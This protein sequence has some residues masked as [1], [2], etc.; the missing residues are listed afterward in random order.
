[1]FGSE[2]EHQEDEHQAAEPVVII[3][4]SAGKLDH[5]A[6][7]G[8]LY[9]GSYHTACRRAADALTAN[10]GTILVLSARNGLIPLDRV[11]EPYDMRMGDPGCVTAAELRDQTTRMGLAQA[12]NVTILAGTAYTAAARAVW[13]HAST[14]LAGSRGIGEHRTRL[15]ALAREQFATAV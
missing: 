10:G 5:P 2:N 11:T 4:C 13:P 6:P 8:K 1:M 15:A 7:A 12:A 3:P 9:T 14:P